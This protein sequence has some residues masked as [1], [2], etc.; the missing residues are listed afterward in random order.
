[1]VRR[2]TCVAF[3]L[4]LVGAFLSA[5]DTMQAEGTVK[6]VTAKN[7][8]VTGSD[9]A[10]WVFQATDET[11][12]TAKGASHKMKDLEE[13]GEAKT[14]DNFIK[15][16]QKVTVTYSEKDGKKYAKEIRVH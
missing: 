8:T 1:M 12:I 11:M 2:A 4:L 10:D 13:A 15:A 16:D 5:G 14:I 3:A 6:A 7:L 9:G